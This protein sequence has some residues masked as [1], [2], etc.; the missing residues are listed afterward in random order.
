MPKNILW[1]ILICG[2]SFTARSQ[3]TALFNTAEIAEFRLTLPMENWR[4]QLDSLRYNGDELLQ[5]DLLLNGT[6]LS[7]I[8]LR[9]QADRAFTPGSSR[10]GLFIHLQAFGEKQEVAGHQ[11]FQLNSALRDPSMIREVLAYEMAG[12]YFPTPKANFVKVYI[13]DEFYGLFTNVETTESTFLTSNFGQNNGALYLAQPDLGNSPPVEGCGSKVYGSLQFEPNVACLDYNYKLLNGNWGKLHQLTKALNSGNMAQIEAL[14]NI[15]ATL[16]MLA[17]NNVIVNLN[18]YS[19]QYAQN[20]YLYEGADGKLHP[21]LHQLNLAFGSFKND[22]SNASDL[23][24]A[25]LLA[26]TPNLHLENETRPLIKVLLSNDTYY[27]QYLSHYRTILVEQLLSGRLENR[28][29][30]MQENIANAVAMDRNKFYTSVEFGQSLTETIGKR[31]RIPGLITFINKRA[32]WLQK[33]P[34][35]TLVPPEISRVGVQQRERFSSTLLSEFRVRATVTGY[36]KKVFVYY[37][38]TSSEPFQRTEM[39]NDGEHHDGR[40]GDDL[41]GGVVVPPSG[42]S[43]LQYYI[44]VENAKTVNYSPSHYQFEQYQTTLSEVNQ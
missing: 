36:P 32:D 19:G 33:Q 15:D 17:F 20:Y 1:L 14:L 4:Y 28:A 2:L 11:T 25:R 6:E 7:N 34:V 21:L 12:T 5:G 18:S 39:F 10:N 16:W 3:E 31:S 30:A 13:N 27:K 24:N 9:Y 26:L 40:A 44:M 41:F 8:G 37:R 42:K 35:Y 29:K 43:E 38:F 23:D 22:G